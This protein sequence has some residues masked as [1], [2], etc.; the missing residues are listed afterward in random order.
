MPVSNDNLFKI[1]K[2]VHDEGLISASLDINKNCDIFKGHFPGQSVV[3]GACMLQILKDV[4]EKG[5]DV[6]L[7]LKKADH[8]KFIVMIDPVDTQKVILDIV[9][10]FIDEVDVNITAKLMSGDVVCFKFQGRFVK[11]GPN[12]Y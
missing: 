1:S 12:G 11:R 9:Y 4:L 10:K 2:L 3:P 6:S 7:M 5:L 8:L